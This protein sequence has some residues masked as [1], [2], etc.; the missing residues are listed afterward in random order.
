MEGLESWM[1]LVQHADKPGSF[2]A[3]HRAPRTTP[4]EKQMPRSCTIGSGLGEHVIDVLVEPPVHLRPLSLKV[5]STQCQVNCKIV[6]SDRT[7]RTGN[8]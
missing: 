4:G 3:L 6:R 5:R 2:S 1:T 7:P 8:G